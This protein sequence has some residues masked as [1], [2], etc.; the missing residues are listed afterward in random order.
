[1]IIIA[2]V[3]TSTADQSH[4]GHQ[5]EVDVDINDNIDTVKVKVTLVY[6]DLD[7]DRFY[8]EYGGMRCLPTDTILTL[9]RRLPQDPMQF[10]VRSSSSCCTLI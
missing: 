5:E 3:D 7:P 9:K 1:M 8:L 2:H 10:Y 4:R 6:T